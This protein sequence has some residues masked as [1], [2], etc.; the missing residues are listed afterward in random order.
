[1]SSCERRE[2]EKKEGRTRESQIAQDESLEKEG[3]VRFGEADTPV[4]VV[5]GDETGDL[6]DGRF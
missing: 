4:D 6:V 2:G 3:K 1:M 5:Q